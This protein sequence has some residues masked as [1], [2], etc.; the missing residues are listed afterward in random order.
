MHTPQAALEKL[1]VLY[2]QLLCGLW[3]DE[4]LTKKNYNFQSLDKKCV[5]G[6]VLIYFS[7]KKIKVEILW[8]STGTFKRLVF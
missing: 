8:D 2:L 7:E 5:R 6:T 3:K 4:C 1:P